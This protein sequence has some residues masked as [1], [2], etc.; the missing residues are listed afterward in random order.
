MVTML[1]LILF[2]SDTCKI[3]NTFLYSMY[4]VKQP[5]KHVLLLLYPYEGNAFARRDFGQLL[6]M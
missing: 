1:R 5:T 6:L 3:Q 2:P 4:G